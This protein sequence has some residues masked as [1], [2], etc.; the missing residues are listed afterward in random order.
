[1]GVASALRRTVHGPAEER[2][3]KYDVL[4]PSTQNTPR[5]P[6]IILGGLRGL[7]DADRREHEGEGGKRRDHLR[8]KARARRR[9]GGDGLHVLTR[10]T[11]RN[12]STR[13]TAA[14]IDGTSR[15]GSSSARTTT[16][17][18]AQVFCASGT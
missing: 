3:K 4:T 9:F 17:V 14:R 16:V 6:R 12:G 18:M 13:A 8:A 10:G 1:M 2:V 11:I 15:I 7:C 5:I